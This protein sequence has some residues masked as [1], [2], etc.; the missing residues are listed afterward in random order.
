MGV[1]ETNLAA[2]I[3]GASL[4]TNVLDIGP[5]EAERFVRLHYRLVGTATSLTAERDRNFRIKADNGSEYVLK[6]AHPSEK[7]EVTNFQIS[8]LLHLASSAP[9]LPVQRIV[10]TMNGESEIRATF[11]NG[12][13]SIAR[14]LS[15]IP[16]DVLRTSRRTA[17]QRR[18]LGRILAEIG[19]ALR[20]FSHPAAS[21]EIAWDLKTAN[22]L[23]SLVPEIDL[24]TERQKMILRCLDIF[25]EHVMPRLSE[26]R[27]QVVHNDLHCDNVIVD[28]VDQD[29]IVGVLD[30]GDM[31]HTPLVNDVAIGAA[32]Q[33][34]ESNNPL[35]T[36]FDFIVG[37]NEV[38]PLLPMEIE[39]LFDLISTRIAMSLIITNW[40]AA[41][42][43]ERRGH[44]LRNSPSYWQQLDGLSAI[45]RAS[46]ISMIRQACE[47]GRLKMSVAPTMNV[48][49]PA[50]VQQLDAATAQLI[51]RRQRAL[52]P[53]YRLFYEHPV[54]FVRG[55]GVWL[56][57]PQGRQY[58]DAYNNVPSVGHCHPHVVSAIARQA[59]LLN[60]HT[61]YLFD[62]VVDYAEQLLTTF[63]A[64]IG[65]VMFTCSGSEA[66]DLAL[67]I[68]R[69]AA[70]GPGIIVTKHAYHGTTTAA[71]E[72]SSSR[73]TV[74]ANVRTVN[75]PDSYRTNGQNVEAAF[76]EGVA[77]AIHSFKRDGVAFAGMIIDSVFSSDGL[78]VQPPGFLQTAV[79]VVREAGGLYIAD[80]VQA[81]FGRTA[82]KMWGFE[83]HG[84]V[85]DLVVMGKPMGNG[86]P[87]GGV[88]ARPELLGEF[89]KNQ[90][91]FNTF[92]GNPVCCAAALAVLDVL[93]QDRLMENASKV[94]R[95][96]INGFQSLA[97]RYPVIGDVRG[98]GLSFG[99]E[100][101]KDRASKEPDSRLSMRI[102]NALREDRIL[103]S[104]LGP[105][106]SVLK[107]R[108]PLPFSEGNADQ[109]LRS[110]DRILSRP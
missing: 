96:L 37:Y 4:V 14:L 47:P 9:S 95:Y 55:E 28:P 104:T 75:A 43:P 53:C 5:A 67:R 99:V 110:M 72:V 36:A 7:P 34:S 51:A 70:G 15:Y 31:V 19:L 92:A 10:R 17:T 97:D 89:G 20:N 85:P 73:G 74:S 68:A 18:N 82:D 87:I 101:V 32:N 98:A 107:I 8:A 42:F 21:Y 23:K 93:A 54:H 66:T 91:Y 61:R 40:R 79:K 12:T 49:D 94:G 69:A 103:I 80:E 50:V 11:D 77:E 102:V 71:A 3:L 44:I 52:G 27:S 76:A 60:T 62:I 86:M 26:L 45:S 84:V 13:T 41:K 105:H 6:I 90:R 16:G 64:E 88:A 106:G 33:L 2:D 109:L 83:R 39:L 58:L 65:N 25:D 29:R 56:F 63:P 22:R 78:Y 46:A 48:F 108:P 59:A 81:G 1:S 35:D 38:A 30:F 57:D 24:A 100:C